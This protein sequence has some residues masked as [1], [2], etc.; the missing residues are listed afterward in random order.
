MSSNLAT[1]VEEGNSAANKSRVG[2]VP[3]RQIV[4]ATFIMMLYQ[5]YMTAINGIASPWIAAG[6]GL[7]E[8]EIAR[9]YAWISLS[10]IGALVISRYADRVGRRRVLLLCMTATPLL[11][12]AAAL[13]TNLPVFTIFDIGVYACSTATISSSVVLIA[14]G[15]PIE[16]RAKGQSWGGMALGLGGGVCVVLVPILSA[17]GQSWRWLLFFGATGILLVPYMRRVIPESERWKLAAT[18]GATS[19]RRFYDVFEPAYRARTIPVLLCSLLSMSAVT[20]VTSWGYFHAVS[21]NNLSPSSASLMTIIGGGLSFAGLAGGAWGAERF[22]RVPTVAA[23]G[24]LLASGGMFFYW[25][26]PRG[27]SAPAVWLGGGFGWFMI[28]VNAWMVAGNSIATELFP[29]AL[30]STMLGWLA[31][32]QAVASVTCQAIIAVAAAAAGG[33]SIVVGY[34]GLLA[35]PSAIIFAL[36]IEETR[37]LSLEAA[38]REEGFGV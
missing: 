10:A 5:G 3:P 24:L 25:G 37:G 16:M 31:L 12:L 14:E 7:G 21:V 17:Q 33:L 32:V 20:A 6:F 27:F 15:L 29:T 22:G 23:A 30:R 1:V 28:A 36:T 38:A 9:L 11:A 13:S 4:V 2:V 8:S 34:V 35:V 18:T 19:G 26:P